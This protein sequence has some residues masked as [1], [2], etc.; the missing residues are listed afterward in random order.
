MNSQQILR[1][2][3]ACSESEEWAGS[4]T[5]QEA[6]EA[7][8]RGDWLLW[9]AGKLEIDRKLLVLA[10]CDCARLALP[11]VP[12]G[13]QR[14]LKAIETAEA[15]TRGEASLEEVKAAADA[16]RASANAAYAA[17]YTAYTANTAYA[18]AY[19]AVDAANAANAVYAANA[20]AYAADA[21]AK[22]K[23]QQ[24]CAEL[25]RARITWEMVEG[26]LN[27]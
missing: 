3:S 24:K 23:T 7:C 13:E 15:W 4:R 2:L 17:A 9:L 26:K 18:A 20:A 16:A 22:A 1:F 19:A 27:D 11:F 21:D 6:W 12:E 25:V 5:P 14:P 8:P 10:A